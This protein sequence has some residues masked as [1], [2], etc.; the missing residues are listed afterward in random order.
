MQ[1][2]SQDLIVA[3]ILSTAFTLFIIVV[4]I[5]FL[6][7]YQKRHNDHIQEKLVMTNQFEQEILKTQLEIREQTVK[8]ISQEI[9]DNIGQVLSLA[10]LHLNTMPVAEG[11][12]EKLLATRELVGKAIRDLRELS[13]Y[14]VANKGIDVNLAEEI[15]LEVENLK[16]LDYYNIDFQI[17]GKPYRLAGQEELILF[18]IL[19]ELMNNIIKHAQASSIKIHLAYTPA[20]LVIK[21]EDNGVGF[22]VEHLNRELPDLQ[23]LGL[24][25][26]TNRATL[27]GALLTITSLKG[28]GTNTFIQINRNKELHASI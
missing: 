11:S 7:R 1:T 21:I 15:E 14:L 20:S 17:E 26:M 27:I 16:K 8:N 25:N 2:A 5:M 13:R 9:H 6:F 18:R 28:Q 23:G 3:V 24:R 4:V 10:K 12:N 22:D 19:Q